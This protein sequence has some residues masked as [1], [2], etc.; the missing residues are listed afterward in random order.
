MNGQRPMRSLLSHA[1][2]RELA[3]PHLVHPSSPGVALKCGQARHVAAIAACSFSVRASVSSVPGPL[4][5]RYAMSCVVPLC[6]SQQTAA[7]R[8][9]R[10]T[11]CFPHLSQTCRHLP[12]SSLLIK[13]AI[14]N[15][16]Q[17]LT[18]NVAELPSIITGSDDGVIQKL[19][20]WHCSWEAR[21][22]VRSEN[23]EQSGGEENSY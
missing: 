15:R 12:P 22:R 17:Q 8:G 16:P 10:D 7:S 6:G 21:D 18:L 4:T 1:S 19:A 3:Q 9:L 2:W 23:E 5:A 11:Y 13:L 14:F 20:H